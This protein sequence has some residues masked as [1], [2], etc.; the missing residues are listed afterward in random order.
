MTGT[1]W[2]GAELLAGPD[3]SAILARGSATVTTGRFRAE[4]SRTRDLLAALG[5]VP[6]STVAVHGTPSF[7]Q[8]WSVFALW[9]LGAQVIL[10]E[11][12]MSR[13]ELIRALGALHPQFHLTIG[14]VPRARHVFADECQVLVRRDPAGTPARTGHCLV[15]LSSGTTGPVK[16]VGRT[17]A[18]LLAELNRATGVPGMPG[19]GDTVLLLESPARSFGLIG[20]VLHAMNVGA[21]VAFCPDQ[22]PDRLAAALAGADVLIATPPT[23]E[24]VAD[25]PPA[26][27]RLRVAVS[28]GEV[29]PDRVAHRFAN[30]HGVLVGQAY[31]TT[32]TGLVAADLLGV[33]APAVGPP[34]PGMRTRVTGGTLRVHLPESPYLDA[35]NRG[36]WFNAYD[37]VHQDPGTGVLRLYGRADPAGHAGQPDVDLLAIERA[38]RDHGL[39]REAVVLGADN[40]IEA[41]VAGP[42]AF[43]TTDLVAWC[44]GRLGTAPPPIRL[45]V[46]PTLPR[47]ANGKVLRDPERLHAHR[48]RTTALTTH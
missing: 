27:G 4:V 34:V 48:A 8:L 17:A 23:I 12:A 14:T 10:A 32:E 18:S 40:M 1:D 47:T 29:L 9:E 44:Q 42:G 25:L 41:H 6:G 19:P 3:S 33:H 13:T 24:L 20:G 39:I 15:Q 5:V 2:W 37:L 36:G 11:A 45:H 26:P 38:L 43:T 7:T 35:T 16:P 21:T 22:R 46:L 28:G 30:R 31:G